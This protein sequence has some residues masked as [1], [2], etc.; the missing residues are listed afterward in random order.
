MGRALTVRNFSFI[1]RAQKQRHAR[2]FAELAEAEQEVIVVS[3]LS[4]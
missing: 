1:S 4:D 3:E 2:K